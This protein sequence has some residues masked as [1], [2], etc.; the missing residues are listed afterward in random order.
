MKALFIT[1]AGII[2]LV[3]CS[4]VTMPTSAKSENFNYKQAKAIIDSQKKVRK[5][6]MKAARKARKKEINEIRALSKN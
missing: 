6:Q 1:F 2:L 4:P 3:A 5:K